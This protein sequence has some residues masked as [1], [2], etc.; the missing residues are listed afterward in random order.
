M[1]KVF[2]IPNCDQVKK[3][4]KWL[5]D[6]GIEFE[7]HDYKK[8]NITKKQLGEWC[9]EIKWEILLN[10]RSRTWKEISGKELSE[11]DKSNFTQAKAITL[12]QQNPTLIKRPVIQNGK[13]ITVGFDDKIFCQNYK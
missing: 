5:K 12:M 4:Q 2:G 10:K 13:T 11:K 9:K 6:R 7:F 8:Q 1:L 3:S